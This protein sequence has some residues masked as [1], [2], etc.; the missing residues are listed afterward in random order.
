[1]SENLSKTPETEKLFEMT[2]RNKSKAQ[3]RFIKD[4]GVWY[5]DLPHKTPEVVKKK[6]LVYALPLP[7]ITL[8]DCG[9]LRECLDT[10][11]KKRGENWVGQVFV[12]IMAV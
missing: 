2:R 6:G 5:W 12:D 4:G 7:D 9:T 1:M 3:F 8:D 10:I 11:A